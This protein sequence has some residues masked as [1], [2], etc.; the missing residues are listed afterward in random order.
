MTPIIPTA[1]FLLL[2]LWIFGLSYFRY[3]RN[4]KYPISDDEAR[5]YFTEA[6]LQR[7]ARI[8]RHWLISYAVLASLALLSAFFPDVQVQ[9]SPFFSETGQKIIAAAITVLYTLISVSIGYYCAYKK[10]GTMWLL[11]VIVAVPVG[12]IFSLAGEWKMLFS[13]LGWWAA[14]SLSPSVAVIAWFWVSCLRLR[15]VNLARRSR[16]ELARKEKYPTEPFAM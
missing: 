3:R 12:T 15:A 16:I 14:L 11:L 9:Q 8:R 5:A 10:R 1:L 7:E 2:A 4:K 6:D 13:Q